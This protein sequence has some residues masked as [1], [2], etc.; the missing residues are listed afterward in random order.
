MIP[1]LI[2]RHYHFKVENYGITVKKVKVNPSPG[3]IFITFGA[4]YH[5]NATVNL[6]IWSESVSL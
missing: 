6:P 1:N 5:N 4:L 3:F 2:R